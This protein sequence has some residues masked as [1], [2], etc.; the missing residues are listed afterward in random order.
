GGLAMTYSG[1][2]VGT[3]YDL[4][5]H[6][7]LLGFVM[8]MVFGHGPIILPAVLKRPLEFKPALY[9]PLLLLHAGLLA[10]VWADTAGMVEVRQWAGLLNALTILLYFALAAPK[11]WGKNDIGSTTRR[12]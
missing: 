4:L 3:A 11:P 5:L 6:S 12:E 9:I 7:V 10:R 1:V 2:T 8:A